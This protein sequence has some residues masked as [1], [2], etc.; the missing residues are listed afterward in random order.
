MPR[1][2]KF[3]AVSDVRVLADSC[4]S[5]FLFSNVF[6]PRCAEQSSAQWPP[7]IVALAG[8]F[9]RCPTSL[10]LSLV[11]LSNRI[12]TIAEALSAGPIA[13]RGFFA[14]LRAMSTISCAGMIS[15]CRPRPRLFWNFS[16]TPTASYGEMKLVTPSV[17]IIRQRKLWSFIFMT[18][19][20]GSGET[21][22][23]YIKYIFADLSLLCMC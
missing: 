10:L 8:L 3:S 20:S 9:T 5:L 17:A 13:L 1:P 15:L 23:K 6:I 22:N 4:S 21:L 14:F 12:I 7:L 11:S 19:M 2:E 18:R 16:V